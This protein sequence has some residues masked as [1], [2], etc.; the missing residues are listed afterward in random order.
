M[1]SVISVSPFR[2]RMWAGHNR[3]EEQI[4]EETC[5]E[6]IQSFTEHGQLLPVLARH[7]RA[8]PTHDY[9]LIFGSRRLFVACH[10]NVA[11]KL[12]V[13][14]LTDQEAAIALDIE[15]R[16]R[17]DL[18]PYERG[19]S[20]IN[21]LR[22]GLFASQEE[23]ARSVG[24]SASQVSRLIR[25]G[26]LPSVLLGVFPSP[27]EIC[28]KWGR[29]LMDLWEDP[30][31][32]QII[33]A[34]AREMASEEPRPS[35]LKAYKRLMATV[36]RRRRLIQPVSPA[37]HEE[38]VTD[39]D[40]SPLFRIS[41]QQNRIALLLLCEP[42]L[43][44]ALAEI[45]TQ[46]AGLVQRMRRRIRDERITIESVSRVPQPQPVPSMGRARP[47]SIRMSARRLA[48]RLSQERGEL[49]H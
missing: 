19:R 12:E 7:L 38:V 13:R 1:S 14:V 2:C 28:E 26:Q 33:A 39:S 46:L 4:T 36:G 3:L 8:D 34:A 9:E 32:K 47:V 29:D 48:E 15:N 40:G 25:L 30:Q 20:Y 44:D 35:A 49:G 21:W 5:R 42:L 10:L 17:R 27:V 22:E 18:S 16:Q 37:H 31:R 45:K 41:V 23:L 6:E 11:L 43:D 24:I